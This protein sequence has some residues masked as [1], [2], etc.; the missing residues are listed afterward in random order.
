MICL[1]CGAEFDEMDQTRSD[2]RDGKC[3]CC[4][5]EDIRE[6]KDAEGSKQS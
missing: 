2:Y 5:G 4:G 1:D 6:G 3:P